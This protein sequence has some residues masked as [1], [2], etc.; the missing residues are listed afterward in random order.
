MQYRQS[1][2]VVVAPYLLSHAFGALTCAA[3]APTTAVQPLCSCVAKAAVS[4][5]PRTGGGVCD[6]TT[7]IAMV[8]FGAVLISFS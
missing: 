1:H 2:A 3:T 4:S 5:S 8:C 6:A 7:F